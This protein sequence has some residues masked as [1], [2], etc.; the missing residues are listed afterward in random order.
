[1]N[2]PQTLSNTWQLH[3]KTFCDEISDCFVHHKSLKRT[4]NIFRGKI[5]KDYWWTEDLKCQLPPKIF[6]IV[7]KDF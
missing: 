3:H 2:P 4:S 5:I 1:M 6:N 7:F